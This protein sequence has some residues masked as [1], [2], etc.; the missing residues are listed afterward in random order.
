MRGYGLPHNDDVEYPDKM[1]VTIYG[2]KPTQLGEKRKSKSKKR[3][4][5][6]LK[7]IFRQEQKNQIRN[8]RVA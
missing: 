2:L 1:D 6:I 3:F 5:R 8:G 7:K 4:R